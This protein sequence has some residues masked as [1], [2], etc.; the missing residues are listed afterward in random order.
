MSFGT[1][2]RA[3]LSVVMVVATAMG[4]ASVFSNLTIL[5]L[6]IS[7]VDARTMVVHPY[8]NQPLPEG[9]QDGDRIDLA[10]LDQ[11]T[12]EAL[13]ADILQGKLPLGHRYDL[14][15]L[16]DGTV[17]HAPITV[18]SFTLGGWDLL[19]SLLSALTS[20]VLGVVTLL[21]LW[22]GRD[23]AAYGLIAWTAGY[24]IGTAF[25]AI[26]SDGDAAAVLFTLSQLCYVGARLGFYVMAAALVRDSL[27][28]RV[29]SIFHG[30]FAVWLVVGSAPHVAG[31]VLFAAVG[32]AEYML[33]RYQLL[34]SWVYLVPVAMLA[35]GY[36]R[37]EAGQRARLRWAIVCGIS[38]AISVTMTNTVPPGYLLSEL[39]SL[40]LFTFTFVGMAYA[41]LRHRV[42]DVS[43]VIDRTLVYGSMTAL[44]VGVVAA[45]NS[46]ALRVALP[47]GAGLLLQVV[48]PLSLGIVLG[49]LRA[50]MDRIV[51]QVFFRRKYQAEQSLR[52]FAKRAGHIDQA[53]DLLEAT[54]REVA[55][56]TGTPAVAIYSVESDGFKRMR[57]AGEDVFPA[58]LGNND[59]AA[60]ALRAE[61]QATDLQGLSSALGPDGCAIPM[62]VLGNLRGLLVVKNRAGEH[63][64][65]DEKAL[66]TQV[67]LDVGAAW[68]ILR[69]RDNEALVAAMATG[70]V[71][72]EKAFAEARKLSLGWAGG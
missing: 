21:L 68:R 26:P 65:S 41:L 3:S 28:A 27:P 35:M 8:E 42:V 40:V 6:H 61:G 37:I 29:R 36:L 15:I 9:L 5:P 38:L 12:R 43:I 19:Q 22:R 32:N 2:L 14:S 11:G 71:Q 62:L 30:V 24:N 70:A 50:F 66:L 34:Y 1:G 53:G 46:L 16:R 25:S 17:V 64:G 52:A 69:A 44:V 56:H 10:A 4:I 45:V 67:A 72:A 39:A 63:F 57:H 60:V 13:G 47:P 18:N 54:A 58:S 51:E 7:L 59:D 31:P 55:R 33:S 48:V 23:A 20:L 49:K